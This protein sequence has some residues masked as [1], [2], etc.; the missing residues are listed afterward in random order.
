MRGAPPSVAVLGA[1]A[2]TEPGLPPDRHRE[3]LEARLRGF[4]ADVVWIPD[5][6]W[7]GW[8]RVAE[9]VTSASGAVGLVDA[10]FVGHT[11]PLADTIADSRFG[12]A[13]LTDDRGFNGV[14][15][16]DA[17]DRVAAAASIR[18]LAA[19]RAP[20]RVASLAE[21]LMT[22]GVELHRVDP[23]PY[24]AGFA[25]GTADARRLLQ[26]VNDIDEHRLRLAASA[27]PRDGFYSTFVVR[28]VSR[29]VTALAL[30]L[31]LR[32]NAITASSL[33]V[34]LTAAI[35]F[36]AGEQWA[37]VAGAILLQV[38]LVLDCVDGEV[39]RY[40]RQFT[41][42][43]AWLD[44]VGDRVKEFAAYAGL[45]VGAARSGETVWLLAC[46]ALALL[47]VRHHVDFGF[48]T[49]RGAPP[50]AYPASSASAQIRRNRWG[51]RAEAWS[52]RTNRHVVLT[53]AKRVVTMPIG[54]RWLVISVVAPIW[55]PRAVF[56][57]LL[58][59]GTVA[60]LYTTTGRVMRT[61]SD[62]APEPVVAR[63]LAVLTEVP[64]LV[65][66]SSPPV[67]LAG[68]LGWL[69]PATARLFES[70]TIIALATSLDGATMIAAF[71]MLAVIALHL[72]D[73]VYRMRHLHR[74]PPAWA[75]AAVLGSVSRP[76]VLA[77]A[78][79][80]GPSVFGTACVALGALVIVVSV[81]D[82]RA[83][84]HGS[85]PV[86]RRLTYAEARPQ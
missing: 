52:E 19:A 12:S 7:S 31:H 47:V 46:S 57:V 26:Q 22:S 30:R 54:E 42:F 85:T 56:I 72:Y 73:L 39:A 59:T 68:R 13:L 83:S 81:V 62:H 55:G 32:P 84:W 34:G 51:N 66:P 61:M 50:L 80:A 58:V 14:L 41:P 5:V 63:D 38:S 20:V 25:G 4:A 71:G 24:V 43:G 2:T 75:S 40:T 86:E 1:A 77:V 74:P 67:W 44:A 9:A 65:N 45:A 33:V 70:V 27:R 11:A 35:L 10:T 28:K 53:W 18:E 16:I 76:A 36:A 8:E 69:A 78:V 82:G 79:M 6:S 21:Q 37:L 48:A 15:K 29:Q 17:A 3:W 23:G 49:L 60:A 64:V